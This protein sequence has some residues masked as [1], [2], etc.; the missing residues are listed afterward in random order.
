MISP[1]FETQ[2]NTRAITMSLSPSNF[3]KTSLN[4]EKVRKKSFTDSSLQNV[5]SKHSKNSNMSKYLLNH[6]NKSRQNVEDDTRDDEVMSHSSTL[7][8]YRQYDLNLGK[9]M[10]DNGYNQKLRHS[11]INLEVEKTLQKLGEQRKRRIAIMK[12]IDGNCDVPI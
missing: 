8:K 9:V 4:I 6:S 2:F 3:K 1:Q 11:R 5:P 7:K 12:G 10:D